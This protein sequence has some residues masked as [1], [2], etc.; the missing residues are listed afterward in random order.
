LPR[1]AR[2]GLLG[3][4][5]K[6]ALPNLI[7]DLRRYPQRWK[8]AGEMLHPL[9]YQ[10]LFPKVAL[11]FSLLRGQTKL[12]PQ[13][14]NGFKPLENTPDLAMLNGQYRFFSWSNRTQYAFANS[15][16]E[17]LPRLLSERPGEFGRRLDHALR[18]CVPYPDYA[19]PILEAFSAITP[20]LTAPMLLQ[21][22]AHFSAREQPL[23]RRVFFPKGEVLLSYSS[24]DKRVTL[25]QAW[26][27]A[28]MDAL[29]SELLS[30]AAKLPSA[31]TALL[32]VDLQNLFVPLSERASSKALIALPRG[33]RQPV[34]QGKT[35]RL[36]MH[37]MQREPYCVDLDLSFSFFDANWRFL[38]GCDFTNLASPD[39]AY[40]HSGDYTD[41]PEPNGASEYID[42]NLEK[43][44]KR[45]IRYCMMIVFSYNSVPFD[46]MPFAMAGMMQ[47]AD[48]T[49]EIFE[50]RTVQNRFDLSGNAQIAIPLY[51]DLKRLEMQW[52]DIK[53]TPEGTNH[54]VGGYHKKLGAI[55]KDFQNYYAAGTRPTLWQLA[56]VHAAARASVVQ[57]RSPKSVQ[58]FTKGEAAP[59][60]FFWR[61]AEQ[62]AP[63]GSLEQFEPAPNG[64]AFL[65]RRDLVL[66]PSEVYALYWQ[67]LPSEGLHKQ[68]A[69][70][71]VDALKK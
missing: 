2:R 36:F 25:P 10:K 67:D 5:E 18:L 61:I 17:S 34:P 30:R 3:I 7:E 43:L 9:E 68:R 29:L 21:L 70:D 69:T 13:V 22:Q 58:V 4:L 59:L 71:L 24:E 11:A 52:L 62:R 40:T 53:L 64:L 39:G 23:R 48:S 12:E 8:R 37:W 26:C 51:L 20:K 45:G 19:A 15:I 63:D 50:P 60:D 35:V 41:A 65:L 44:Q 49:G 38:E 54:Q 55:G 16:L 33:S 14:I 6:F 47:R 28:L 57:V 46:Q 31:Q 66:P 1:A 27:T 56:C 32:D 42:L